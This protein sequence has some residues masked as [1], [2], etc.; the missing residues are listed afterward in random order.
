MGNCSKH[1]FEQAVASCA[2]CSD[3]FCATCTVRP[4]GSHGATLCLGCALVRAGV[5]T[6]ATSGRKRFGIFAAR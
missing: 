2:S 1:L 4:Y 3:A 6:R 5:R